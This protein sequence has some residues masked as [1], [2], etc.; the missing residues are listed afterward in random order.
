MAQSYLCIKTCES[1]Q[2]WVAKYS[3]SIF[4][5]RACCSVHQIEPYSFDRKV[6]DVPIR[7]IP[8]FIVYIFLILFFYLGNSLTD[9]SFLLQL[10]I[11]FN[12]SAIATTF[13]YPF[14]SFDS[15]TDAEEDSANKQM[16]NG[17]ASLGGK[18]LT[19][20]WTD[21]TTDCCTAANISQISS[22]LGASSLASYKPSNMKETTDS[23]Q[24]G[25]TKSSTAPPSTT[26]TL[27]AS[28]Q[29]ESLSD[30]VNSQHLVPAS[31]DETVS[32]SKSSSASDLLF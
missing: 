19:G 17:Q 7:C 31:I 14:D 28:E 29:P 30:D 4:T 6:S 11:Q 2:F 10:S 32:F 27:G 12:D 22:Q 5:F 16:T 18:F 21:V 26:S 15:Y 25:I 1:P 3:L 23:F 9:F 24:L 20:K 8:L 13:E